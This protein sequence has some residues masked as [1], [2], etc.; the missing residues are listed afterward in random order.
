MLKEWGMPS[1]GPDGWL[2]RAVLIRS[3]E[4]VPAGPGES[5]EL[6]ARVDVCRDDKILGWG[7]IGQDFIIDTLDVE[8]SHY[9]IFAMDKVMISHPATI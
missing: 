5:E 4:R 9:T 2:P 8:S 3:T 1:T 7:E 6:P